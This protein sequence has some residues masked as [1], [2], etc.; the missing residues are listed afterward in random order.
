MTK[1]KA[2][3]ARQ[4]RSQHIE[5]RAF[6]KTPEPAGRVRRVSRSRNFV[7]QE[8]D[9][10]RLHYAFRLAA[11]A[12]GILGSAERALDEPCGQ[13]LGREDG[14]PSARICEVRGRDSARAIRS[15]NGDGLRLGKVRVSGRPA[16][17]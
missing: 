11:K 2:V 8:H 1:H 14:G 5:A 17:K 10:S 13:A 6:A 7:V 12:P 15:R 9:A 16:A 3:K 4:C